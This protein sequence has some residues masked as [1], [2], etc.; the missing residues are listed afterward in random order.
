S[1]LISK[2]NLFFFTTLHLASLI[3]VIIFTRN[4][5]KQLLTLNK[6]A[7]KMWTYL[8][9]A[10]IPAALAGLLFNDII[11]KAFSS[12][13][14]LSITF[15]FTGTILLLTKL[16]KQDSNLNTKNATIIGLLQILAL[17]P[18]VSRSGITISSGLFLGL[19]KEKAARFSFLLL[20]PLAAGAF[21]LELTKLTH[22][23]SNIYSLT[24]PFTICLLASLL[25]LNI[26]IKIIKQNKF[27]LFAYYCF[28][29]S[30]ISLILHLI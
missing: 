22:I 8:I 2:P 19:E 23:P 17:F 25:F 13:L 30:I 26:L 11:E 9:I 16:A 20:I 1:N 10:T 5:I 24:I 12:Y 28:A 7:K 15:L 6:Q 21:I 29:L 27:H 14:I 3:A 4:E 18:G